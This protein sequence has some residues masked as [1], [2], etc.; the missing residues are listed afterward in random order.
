MFVWNKWNYNFLIYWICHLIIQTVHKNNIKTKLKNKLLAERQW[1]FENVILGTHYIINLSVRF[2][3]SDLQ[4][5]ED[6]K[7]E[8]VRLLNSTHHG[9]SWQTN[10]LFVQSFVS[11]F[12]LFFI[13]SGEKLSGYNDHDVMSSNFTSCYM[14]PIA[15]SR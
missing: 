6:Y 11:N 9:R 13:F 14:L 5:Q 8:E 4:I 15:L 7:P 12:F 3:I 1:F 2:Y 10:N